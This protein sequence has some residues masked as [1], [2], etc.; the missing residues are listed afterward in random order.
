[1]VPTVAQQLRSLCAA[2]TKAVI[3]A[4]DPDDGFAAE[5]AGLVLATLN[6]ILDVHES[7]YPYEVVE[8]GEYRRL[9][10]GL[11][12]LPVGLH[13]TELETALEAAGSEGSPGASEPPP[14]PALRDQTRRFKELADRAYAVLATGAPQ[15]APRARELMLDV[16]RRQSRRE[17]SWFRMTG[18]PA[19]VEGDI[20]TVLAS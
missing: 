20:A 8:N 7:E 12:E 4:L 18:F 10:A 19:D 9:L 1:M 14:L 15:D 13:D 11:A 2:L 6:W 5:Q 3:P 17:Q 16:A